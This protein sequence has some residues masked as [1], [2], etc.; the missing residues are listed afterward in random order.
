MLE[1]RPAR[2]GAASSSPAAERLQHTKRGENPAMGDTA[3]RAFVGTLVAV[4]VVALAL[5][6]WKLK[7][8]IALVFLGF[9]VAAAMR[10][11][12]DRLAEHRVP[13]PLGVALHY[14]VLA[15][16]IGLLLWLVVPRAINQVNE[17][18]GGVPTSREELNQKAKH[19]SGIKHQFFVG[20]Q[21][22]LAK[23]PS[24]G[25][26]VHGAVTIGTKALEALVGIFFVFAIAA[27]WIFE[28]ERAIGFVSSLLPRKHRRVVRDTWELIDAKLGAYVRGSLLL[29]AFVATV[30]SLSFWAI[31]VPFWLLLG[32][33]G[34]VVEIVPVIG[35]LVAGVAAVGVGLTTSWQV[36]LY[37]GIAVVV[38][39]QFEDYVVIPRVMGHVTG[40]S[41]LLVLVSVTAVGL[42][43]GGF[44]V[45]MATP[46]VALIATL[47]D[48][49]VRDRDP[50]EED[51]PAVLFAKESGG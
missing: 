35:P 27:Y 2:F 26:V 17:A 21:K 37:A 18:I 6:L 25:S 44:Y 51:V 22:R 47:V 16:A 40:L 24:A 13:R 20:L 46:F 11:G 9:I 43:F 28:R 8:V 48:V 34:G 3:R 49:I 33:F 45:L 42:L 38:V 4:A 31:G 29:I 14:V 12:V 1:H 50:A 10:P 23:L 39:R 5:A 30:L 7:I 19:S 15:G 36:A 32:V 41:P